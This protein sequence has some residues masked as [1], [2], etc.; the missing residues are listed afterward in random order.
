MNKIL[1]ILL[2]LVFFAMS[3]IAQEYSTTM[4]TIFSTENESARIQHIKSAVDSKGNLY[5]VFKG[6]ENHSYFGTNQSGNWAFQKLEY[7]NEEYDEF[8]KA[9]NYPNI[10]VDAN[11]KLS[12]VIAGR[13]NENLYWETKDVSQCNEKWNFKKAIIVSETPKFRIMD[14]Y[15]DMCVDKDGGLHFYCCANVGKNSREENW[16]SATYFY[17]PAN[18]EK[19]DM[20]MIMPGISD[21]VSYAADP[22]ITTTGEKIFVTIGGDKNLHFASK[23]ISGGKWSIEAIE[24]FAINPDIYNTWKYET[25]ITADPNGNPVW[26]FYEYAAENEDYYGINILSKSACSNN[27]WTIDHSIDKP[28]DKRAPAIAVSNMGRTY[29][30][31][32]GNSSFYLYIKTCDCN[33]SW[34][35]IFEK[36]DN[37]SHYTDIVI[38]SEN[39]VSAFYTSEYDNN[40]YLLAVE[41]KGKVEICNHYPTISNYSGKTNLK[42][43]EKWTATITAQDPEC[44]KIKFE[45]IIHNEIFTVTDNGN[46]TATI[47][48]TMPEGSGTGTPGLSVWVLDDKHPDIDDNTSVITFEL[49]IT[50]GGTEEG[51]ITVKNPCK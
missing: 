17:K 23:N 25:T 39:K 26:A 34:K 16:M 20:E 40:I 24:E 5:I 42:P 29:L 30:A 50:S 21:D 10:A 33:S 45:S 44:D 11:D 32:G 6:E 47:T 13:Y 28:T 38:D 18:S 37:S 31:F 8:E 36:K 4:K 15:S 1:T 46:G 41:E 48:A 19:W 27:S 51:N 2:P 7:F 3:G 9:S 14:E 43:G 12:I 49:K 35:K 22:S